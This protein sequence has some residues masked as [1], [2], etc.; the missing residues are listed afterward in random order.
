MRTRLLF[1]LLFVIFHSVLYAQF[2][3]PTSSMNPTDNISA[4]T[5]NSAG[6]IFAANLSKGIY[7]STNHGLNWS[8]SGLSGLLP[9]ALKT[10]PNGFLFAL[11]ST[12]STL[13]IYRS[14]NNGV[15]WQAVMSQSISNNFVRSGNI[16]FVND[17]TFVAAMSFTIGPTIGDVAGRIFR[18]TDRGASWQ[19]VSQ[20][21]AGFTE[22]LAL[23]PSGRILAAT[24]LGG[25]K[26]SDNNGSSWMNTGYN[27]FAYRLAVNSQGHAFVGRWTAG[28]TVQMIY[29][30]TD[31]GA[32]WFPTTCTGGDI[33]SLMIDNNDVLYAGSDNR[34]VRR[35][36]DGGDTW[37]F[38]TSGIPN[39]T[40]VLSFAASPDGIL[41]AGTTNLGVFKSGG[42]V[43]VTHQNETVSG[44][45][46]K[47][48]Y[49]N[50]FNPVTRIGFLLPK[51]AFVNLTVYDITGKEAA[52]LINGIMQ[53][54]S[55]NIEFNA[56]GLSSGVYFYRI[57]AGNFTEVRKMTLIR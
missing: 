35:S 50:P 17:S 40:Y 20:I 21:A 19:Q 22:D 29:R 6:E 38:I 46:L 44:F 5:V 32:L 51:Q 48:N 4:L 16:V 1:L 14:T 56:S 8:L 37:E 53:M 33:H 2:W 47:Q 28:D 55:H 13:N 27:I 7:K 25:V 36:S 45:S 3:N 52:V 24:S 12:Q 10:A 41:Y 9:Y 42:L 11:H 43:T 57:S 49:P 39:T 30:S 31:N 18:S 54:G 23:L 26:A 34:V 15:S